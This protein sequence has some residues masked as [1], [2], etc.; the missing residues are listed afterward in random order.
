MV[1]KDTGNKGG[2]GVK[3]GFQTNALQVDRRKCALGWIYEAAE[4]LGQSRPKEGRE[5]CT[6]RTIEKRSTVRPTIEAKIACRELHVK[7][8]S[9]YRDNQ[10]ERSNGTFCQT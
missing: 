8:R 1:G 10:K 2:G 7:E 9:S 3:S 5:S 4:E 6:C